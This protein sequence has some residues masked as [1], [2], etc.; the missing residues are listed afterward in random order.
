MRSTANPL[1]HQIYE[2]IKEK[3]TCWYKT[4]QR[5]KALTGYNYLISEINES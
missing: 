1:A 4:C 2:G 3:V 5:P